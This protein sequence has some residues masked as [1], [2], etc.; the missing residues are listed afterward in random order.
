MGIGYH[1]RFLVQ[2]CPLLQKFIYVTGFCCI[3]LIGVVCEAV[4]LRIERVHQWLHEWTLIFLLFHV[5]AS[6][7]CNNRTA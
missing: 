1:N 2:H 3:N 7:A 6:K 4:K 5:A